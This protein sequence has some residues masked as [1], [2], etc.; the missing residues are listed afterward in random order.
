MRAHEAFS[1]KIRPEVTHAAR[2]KQARGGAGLVTARRGKGAALSATFSKIFRDSDCF[3]RLPH[4]PYLE[5][6]PRHHLFPIFWARV[7]FQR[8]LPVSPRPALPPVFSTPS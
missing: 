8:R 4:S 5:R 6:C 1:Q 3:G 7:S 2:P